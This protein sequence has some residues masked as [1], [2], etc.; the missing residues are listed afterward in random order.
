VPAAKELD[1]KVV[2][3]FFWASWCPECKAESSMI[4]ATWEKYRGQGLVLIAPTQRY[5]FVEEGRSA[6]PDQELRY[7]A[8][9][10]DTYYPFLRQLPTPVTDA[11]YN[12]YGVDS[13]PT[14]VLI[15]RKGIIRRYQ[16][17]RMTPEDLAVAIQSLL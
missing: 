11:N 13:V 8:H 4:S 16:P 15:D 9:V 3:L 12:K 6:A 7:I 10:R 2:L 14:H 1:G 17:G 5:G